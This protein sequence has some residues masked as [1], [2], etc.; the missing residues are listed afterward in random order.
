MSN[1]NLKINIDIDRK[2][3]LFLA[4]ILIIIITSILGIYIVTSPKPVQERP[5]AEVIQP[6]PA[7]S[8]GILSFKVD[9]SPKI[10]EAFYLRVFVSNTQGANLYGFNLTIS[11]P[12]NSITPPTADSFHAV[13]PI[14]I[15]P[16]INA[17]NSVTIVG[18]SPGQ[19]IND[20]SELFNIYMTRKTNEAVTFSLKS[21][22]EIRLTEGNAIYSPTMADYTLPAEPEVAPLTPPSISC[23]AS[24]GGV[25]TWSWGSKPDA[26]S[27]TFSVGMYKET[28]TSTSKSFT[29]T[30]ET[31]NTGSV[32]YSN[33]ITTSGS[34]SSTCTPK[35]TALQ[36]P[37]LSCTP[38]DK[39]INW[40]WNTVPNG[41]YY[42]LLVLSDTYPEPVEYPFTQ[43]GTF[44]TTTEATGGKTPGV[45]YYGN[46][47]AYDATKT[48]YSDTS[49]TNCAMPAGDK[50]TN[51]I[52]G[53]RMPNIVKT[54]DGKNPVNTTIKNVL[55][56][57]NGKDDRYTDL[58][59][60]GDLL[61]SD[62]YTGEITLN[63]AGAYDI[64]VKKENVTL[65][66]K[67]TGINLTLGETLDC[68]SQTANCGTLPDSKKD[69]RTLLSG[70]AYDD[71]L[72]DPK[73]ISVIDLNDIS[74]VAKY[75]GQ[76]NGDVDLNGTSDL[77]DISFIAKNWGNKSDSL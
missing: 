60:N 3:Y 67:F 50:Q 56:K 22:S 71:N 31:P 11:Y 54:I 12:A 45:K 32:Y 28:T 5:K 25:I 16:K 49:V 20:N 46:L 9:G 10:N 37:T 77:N 40:K 8:K 15:Y 68:V 66:R 26:V 14:L 18:A 6:P 65:G 61:N 29:F 72:N 24:D 23:S 70:D 41:V 13:S 34:N 38:T 47:V 57:I 76:I 2:K 19:K 39:G 42:F 51:L 75:W 58:K 21:G 62:Y 69:D 17:D 43:E 53:V 63:Q 55:V 73:L 27:Y 33:G 4:L 1:P 35:L 74:V 52:F 64:Y 36:T 30:S 59:R 44:F 7:I 48:R